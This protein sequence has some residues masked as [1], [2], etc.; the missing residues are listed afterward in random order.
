MIILKGCFGTLN[1]IKESKLQYHKLSGN[2]ESS[3]Q[4]LGKLLELIKY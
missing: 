4:C 1:N 3:L 2:K